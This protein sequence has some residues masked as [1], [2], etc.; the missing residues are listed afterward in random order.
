MHRVVGTPN[1]MAP[2]V[3][4]GEYGRE[5]DMWSLGVLVYEL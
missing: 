5:A 2:E 3:F 4:N 1:Y